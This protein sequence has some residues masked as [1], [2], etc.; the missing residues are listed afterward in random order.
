MV[1]WNSQGLG[2]SQG[3]M[4]SGKSQPVSASVS[5]PTTWV[6]WV[7]QSRRAFPVL[8]FFIRLMEDLLLA[9]VP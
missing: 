6:G 8:T 4:A 3:C 5:P 1:A 7:P 2:L 9:D